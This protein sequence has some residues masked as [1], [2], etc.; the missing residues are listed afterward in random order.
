[1]ES[2]ISESDLSLFETL[3]HPASACSVLF[4][5]LGNLSEFDIEKYS[6]V[7]KYQM[8]SL[9]WDTLFI[10]NKDLTEQE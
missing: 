8:H 2:K 7:R 9:S 6:E 5:N 10:E 1:M 3:V 4:S